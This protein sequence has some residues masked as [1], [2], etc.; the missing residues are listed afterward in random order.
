V[1]ESGTWG[2]SP[3]GVCHFFRGLLQSRFFEFNIFLIFGL[4]FSVYH[5]RF[6]IFGLP[7][8]VCHFWFTIFCLPFSVYHFWFTI[9]CL[10]FSV[11]PYFQLRILFLFSL[12]LFGG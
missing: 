11:L 3:T 1:V 5:F 7:F 2:A 10:P 9:F 12:F 8:L 6:T 4:P